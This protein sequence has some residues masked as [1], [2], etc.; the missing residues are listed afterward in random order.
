MLPFGNIKL[1][2]SEQAA[3]DFLAPRDNA[4]GRS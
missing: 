2:D 1:A 3:V 4:E